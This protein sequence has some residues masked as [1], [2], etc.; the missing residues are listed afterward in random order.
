MFDVK[1]GES[2]R[3]CKCV[4]SM[5]G[6]GLSDF[7]FSMFRSLFGKFAGSVWRV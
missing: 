3:L 7:S 1:D 6:Y 4:Q 2:G 5:L